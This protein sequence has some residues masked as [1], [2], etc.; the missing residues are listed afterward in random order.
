[1]IQQFDHQLRHVYTVARLTSARLAPRRASVNVPFRLELTHVSPSQIDVL[2]AE[3]TALKTLVLTST[4]SSPNRQLH[5]QLQ[6][7]GTRGA[8]KLGH[9]RNKST[10]SA[11]PPSPG[12]PEPPSVPVQ[13]AAKEER[14]VKPEWNPGSALRRCPAS[15]CSSNFSDLFCSSRANLVANFWS[16]NFAC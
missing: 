11:F 8:Y 1:M 14:E 12:K 13:P 15:S 5:P 16:L 2:Q 7:P 6:S 9:S 10:S 3:V 4:P